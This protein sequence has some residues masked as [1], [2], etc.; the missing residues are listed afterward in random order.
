MPYAPLPDHLQDLARVVVDGAFRV[1]TALGPGLLESVYEACLV[2][3][4]DKR[5]IPVQRQVPMPVHYDGLRFD[6]GFRLD[7]LV[8]QQLIVELKAV[9]QVLPV[10]QAQLLTY[11]KLAD[12]RLGLLLNF[13][14]ARIK[15]G[16]TRTVR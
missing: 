14:V 3:E 5:G 9:E 1:H 8:D 7:L 6:A 2:H 10:H 13:N 11:L 12:L 16:I 4:L 15:D